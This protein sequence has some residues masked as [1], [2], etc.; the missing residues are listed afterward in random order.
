ME[1]TKLIAHGVSEIHFENKHQREAKMQLSHRFSYSVGYGQENIC[2]AQLEVTVSDK[3]KPE[4][5]TIK[6]VLFGIFR[7]APSLPREEIHKDSFRLLFPY[8]RALFTTVSANSGIAP[9][10]LPSADIDGQSVYR[11]EMDPRGRPADE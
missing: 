11:V 10:Y 4:L 9:I 7:Y 2:R 1:K 3:E 8:A 5:F 6:A